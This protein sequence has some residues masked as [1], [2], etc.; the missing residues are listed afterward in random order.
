[1][2]NF[3]I[4]KGRKPTPVRAVIYGAEGIGKSTLAAQLPDPL[5][6]DIEGGTHQLDVSRIDTPDT[7]RML[8][9]EVTYIRDND[10]KIKTLVIDTADRAQAL[11]EAALLQDAGV[12]SIEKVGGGYGKGYTALLE[13]FRKELLYRL[14]EII[15][16]GINVCLL[17]H[18]V[19]RKQESPEDPPFDRW[20]LN[21]SKK[22]APEVRAWAD[23][24]LFCNFKIMAIEENGK[25]KAKGNA[26]RFMYA[27]HR[28]TFDAKNR[29]SLPDEMPLE[30][31]P[32]RSVFERK[33]KRQ[34]VKETISTDTPLG[35]DGI[36]E[37]TAETA[38]DAFKRHMSDESIEEDK[39]IEYLKKR[40]KISADGALED[41]P[42]NYIEQLDQ[43]IKTL[44]REIN[45]RSKKS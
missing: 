37:D 24:L 28:P 3:T 11:C 42:D 17:A 12:D 40:G 5:F 27:N 32:I 2:H 8:I 34:A 21:L 22:L 26:R 16:K 30:Y 35:S 13:K 10:L 39:V 15:A 9:D 7:W 25:V 23:L 31:E 43:N 19:M 44:K 36:V 38:L 1:M 6:I 14:D 20:E 33:A 41:L 4:S 45:K 29:Y 18:A